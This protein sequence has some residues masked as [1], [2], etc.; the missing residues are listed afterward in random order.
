[1]NLWDFDG[2]LVLNFYECHVKLAYPSFKGRIRNLKHHPLL[3]LS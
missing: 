1:M 2:N 3:W